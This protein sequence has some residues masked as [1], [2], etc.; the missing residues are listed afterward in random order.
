MPASGK[1]SHRGDDDKAAATTGKDTSTDAP[2]EPPTVVAEAEADTTALT[3]SDLGT[4]AEANAAAADTTSEEPLSHPTMPPPVHAGQHG[5]TST[6]RLPFVTASFTRAAGGPSLPNPLSALAGA[7]QAVTS[8]VASVPREKA[9]FYVGVGALG[10]LGVVDWPVAAVVAA[11]TYVAGKTRGR[12][13]GS[14]N[15]STAPNFPQT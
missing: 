15:D 12:G 8:A 13:T 5:R 6:V 10:V 9:V 1:R 11:G 7:G 2:E 4:L 14:A 3:D